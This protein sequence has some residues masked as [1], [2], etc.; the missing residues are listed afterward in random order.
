MGRPSQKEQ[1]LDAALAGFS[2]A[3]FDGTK[4][5]DIARRAG[6][7]E[8][9]LYRHYASKEALAQ[10]LYSDGM[11][12]ISAALA[13]VVDG[14]GTPTERARLATM[15]AFRLFRERPSAFRFVLTWAPSFCS[16]VDVEPP[17]AI[18][19]RLVVE[20]QASGEFV[21]GDPGMIACLMMGCIVEPIVLAPNVPGAFPNPLS[22]HSC[23]AVIADFV[24]AGLTGARQL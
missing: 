8:G 19:R 23:D 4:I 13:E 7:S 1:I 14:S 6:V 12:W 3:G 17:L 11:T 5:R 24:V 10:A 16:E 15:G 21:A 9:A 22:D 2:E 18:I 20:G